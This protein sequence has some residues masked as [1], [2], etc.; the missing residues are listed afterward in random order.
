[1]LPHTLP[2]TG[3]QKEKPRLATGLSSRHRAG[4]YSGFRAQ[5]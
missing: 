1:M 2:H 4:S 3:K 5:P